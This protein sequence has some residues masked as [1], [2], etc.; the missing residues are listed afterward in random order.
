[1]QLNYKN[2]PMKY[3]EVLKNL[4]EINDLILKKGNNL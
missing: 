2:V 4:W 1:M 3:L